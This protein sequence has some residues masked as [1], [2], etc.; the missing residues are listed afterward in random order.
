M[1][2]ADVDESIAVFLGGAQGEG[3]FWNIMESWTGFYRKIRRF[4]VFFETSMDVK[5]GFQTFSRFMSFEGEVC[6]IDWDEFVFVCKLK[7]QS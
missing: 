7:I 6:W 2:K 3:T 1:V 5:V 4:L